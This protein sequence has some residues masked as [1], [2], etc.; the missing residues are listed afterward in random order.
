M[1]M[2]RRKLVRMWVACWVV[3]AVAMTGAHAAERFKG[4]A[5][6][7]HVGPGVELPAP[8]V[9]VLHGGRSD[10]P[11]VRR[12]SGFD[13]WVEAHD[14]V[15]VYPSSPDGY[16]ND[17]RDAEFA[18]EASRDD[19]GYLAELVV[20]LADEGIIASEA[21]YF[22]GIS[23]G[24]GMSIRMACEFPERVAGL[25]VVATKLP[26]PF[27]CPRYQPVPSLFFYGTEDPVSPHGGRATG[28]EGRG[29][30]NKGRTL[31]ADESIAQWRQLNGCGPHAQIRRRDR[32]AGDGTSLRIV[33]YPGCIAPLRYYEIVGGGHTWPGGTEPGARWLRRLLGPTSEEVDASRAML[34]FW[35]HPAH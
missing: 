24:G 17:G 34:E 3:L 20:H 25:G 26:R 4:R 16:W 29:F 32:V 9:M 21:V 31:P 33:E 18:D 19:A 15:A 30:G 1:P 13:R 35:H 8:A 7:V 12:V 6:E 23:N 28:R 27:R 14:W 22:A 5:Y 11:S 2:G 10:G